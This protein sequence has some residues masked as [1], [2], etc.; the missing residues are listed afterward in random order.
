MRRWLPLASVVDNH[1]RGR[2]QQAAGGTIDH[3]AL[4][5]AE[6]LSVTARVLFGNQP[7]PAREQAEPLNRSADFS[8]STTSA[9]IASG[10]LP[11]ACDGLRPSP[12]AR[13]QTPFSTGSFTT[14]CIVAAVR[15]HE[16]KKPRLSRPA[17]KMAKQ[18]SMNATK[19]ARIDTTKDC[20]GSGE[21]AG[22]KLTELLFGFFE[23][24]NPLLQD[25]AMTV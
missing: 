14:H 18:S 23:I 17:N 3:P 6:A 2:R 10:D 5:C 12:V 20:A 19:A 13:W 16:S 22:W 7:E 9:W 15:Q 8:S 25:V 21:T 11:P 1:S 4:K 24:R